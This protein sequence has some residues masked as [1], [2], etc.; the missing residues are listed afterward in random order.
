M[1]RN[2]AIAAVIGIMGAMMPW[3]GGMSLVGRVAAGVVF[4][5]VAFVWLVGTDSTVRNGDGR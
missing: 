4:T 2:G 1:L 5:A 3:A